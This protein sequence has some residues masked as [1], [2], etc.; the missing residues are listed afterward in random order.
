MRQF[1][2]L[3]Q[4]GV[5]TPHLLSWTHINALLPINDINKIN[6][7][8]KISESQNLS[9][10]QLREKI[11]NKE[12]ERLDDKTKLKLIN[13]KKTKV[14]DFIKN[15]ILIKNKYNKENISEKMLQDLILEDIPSFLSELG[16]GFCF[17]KN[18]YPIKIG[19]RYNYEDLLLY[20][21]VYK[22]L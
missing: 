19:D 9:Y 16:N 6:Y 14:Q 21:V 12:Y 10:R 5:A 20:S 17:I 1:Y 4:K 15:P 7:Y 18:E 8:I 22:C 13:K 2:V 3:I 11:K